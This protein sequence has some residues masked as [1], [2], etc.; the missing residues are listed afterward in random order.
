MII[1]IIKKYIFIYI[2]FFLVNSLAFAQQSNYIIAPSPI[3]YPYFK[4]GLYDI[5]AGMSFSM[6]SSKNLSLMIFDFMGKGRIAFN[7]FLAIDADLGMGAGFGSITPGMPPITP[8]PSGYYAFPEGNSS[9]GIVSFRIRGNVELQIFNTGDMGMIFFIGPNYNYISM[10][11]TTPYY[12]S[13]YTGQTWY[14]YKD[15]LTMTATMIGYQ[16]G[17]QIDIGLDETIRFSP[18]FMITTTSGSVSIV[19][20]PQVE[21]GGNSIGSSYSADIPSTTAMS[22]GMDIYLGE[23]SIGT[24]LQQLQ[25]AQ[26]SNQDAT[27]IQFSVSYNWSNR[28]EKMSSEKEAEDTKNVKSDSP[29]VDSNIP[30]NDV[31]FE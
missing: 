31:K 9:V 28:E 11:I 22:F 6:L 15:V 2:F 27:I 29:N 17:M 23:I 19:D 16:A 3:P 25:S 1:K 12:I 4:S 7:D 14:G 20:N 18:F 21:F 8:F 24:L 10:N 5:N 26:A 30:D 13:Y